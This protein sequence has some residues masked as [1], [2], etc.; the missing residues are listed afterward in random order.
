M[1][2]GATAHAVACGDLDPVQIE[3]GGPTVGEFRSR[4]PHALMVRAVP[5]RPSLYFHPGNPASTTLPTFQDEHGRPIAVL[6][7]YTGIPRYPFRLDLAITSG[8]LILSEFED[9]RFE[10]EP[11]MTPRTRSVIVH[12]Q[13]GGVEIEVDSDAALLRFE[14]PGETWFLP[15]WPPTFAWPLETIN[16]RI[17]AFYANRTEEVIFDHFSP[18]APAAPPESSAAVVPVTLLAMLVMLAILARRATVSACTQAT[19]TSM[20]L[21]SSKSQASTRAKNAR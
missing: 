2:I 15:N 9:L 6:P 5:A 1:M 4:G 20:C 3:P 17:T 19:S 12:Q 21:F 13:S 16:V 18:R 14:L 10:V 11:G 8:T 7:V